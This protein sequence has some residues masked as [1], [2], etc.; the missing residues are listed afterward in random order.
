MLPPEI[1]KLVK[2]AGHKKRQH[3]VFQ[4]YLKPWATG[5]NL[6]ARRHGTA[7]AFPA[8][9]TKVAVENISTS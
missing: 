4:H 7:I 9:T 1:A 6:W 3:Y 8:H 5:G 2:L